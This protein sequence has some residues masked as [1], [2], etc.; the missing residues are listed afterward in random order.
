[1]SWRFV[2]ASV[3]GTDHVRAGTVCQDVARVRLVAREDGERLV[4]AVADGAG[5]ARHADVGARLACEAAV[6]LLASDPLTVGDPT[7]GPRIVAA[8]QAAIDHA[9]SETGTSPRDHACTLLGA[10]IM[11]SRAVFVQ[12]GD[13]AIVIAEPGSSTLGWVFWPDKGEHA[14]ETSFVTGA[15]AAEELEVA[16]REGVIDEVALFTDGLERLAL[17]FGARLA[18]P[19]FFGPMFGAVRALPAGD[20]AE[21]AAAEGELSG[22][23]GSAR[24]NERTS[25][26]KTLVLAT[27]RPA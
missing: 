24:V 18:F 23:L 27:R 12:I 14:N 11:P 16:W 3:I 6:A 25:D 10:A 20:D 1:V 2:A 4:A 13:G 17:D 7:L 9:A 22:F 8:A 15:R 21:L 26:D 19:S 5:S